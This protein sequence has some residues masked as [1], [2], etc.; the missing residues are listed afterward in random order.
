MSKHE[1]QVTLPKGLVVGNTDV[2]IP[3]K[4]DGSPMGRLKVSKG[5]VD[6]MPSGNSKTRHVVTW[7][8]LA[9]LLIEHGRVRK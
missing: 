8:K 3:V 1:V 2:E 5:G 9:E 7:E 4:V 6:W